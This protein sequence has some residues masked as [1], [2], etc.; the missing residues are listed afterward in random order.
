MAFYSFGNLPLADRLKFIEENVLKRF[1]KINPMTDIPHEKR[2]KKEKRV[3][4]SYPASK[5][6]EN[7]KY[8]ASMAW[9]CCDAENSFEVLVFELIEEILKGIAVP[10]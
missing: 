2:Y 8:Q 10:R 7:K 6:D 5:K 4:F 3:T 9:L 1:S